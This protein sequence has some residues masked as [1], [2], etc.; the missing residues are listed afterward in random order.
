M[1]SPKT[2]PPRDERG[3]FRCLHPVQ[4]EPDHTTLK[5]VAVAGEVRPSRES[6]SNNKVRAFPTVSTPYYLDRMQETPEQAAE[7]RHK[8]LVRCLTVIQIILIGIFMNTCTT[9]M[10]IDLK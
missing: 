5:G 10:R 2:K 6:P 1:I 7:R 8:Y 4:R 9:C 3:G